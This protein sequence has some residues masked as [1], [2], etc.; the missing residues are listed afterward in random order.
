MIHCCSKFVAFCIYKNRRY[1]HNPPVVLFYHKIQ[2]AK[3]GEEIQKGEK[4]QKG[5]GAPYRRTGSS[6]DWWQ[7]GSWPEPRHGR[8][9]RIHCRSGYWCGHHPHC[10]QE[11]EK[12]KK[13]TQTPGIFRLGLGF[14]VV[15]FWIVVFGVV[16]FW[17]VVQFLVVLVFKLFQFL[18][19]FVIVGFGLRDFEKVF[20]IGF[21]VH[22]EIIGGR[23]NEGRTST[24][25]LPWFNGKK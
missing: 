20:G 11:E 9:S 10:A 23:R 22:I 7:E 25:S 1:R 12:E 18:F 6:I 19:F 2:H 5:L 13:E 24:K 4:V 21:Y 3:E 16:V 14:G 17:V 15:V 8:R